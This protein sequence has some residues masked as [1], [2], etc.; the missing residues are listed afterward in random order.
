MPGAGHGGTYGEKQAGKFGKAAVAF[1]EY[2]FKGDPKAKTAIFDGGLKALG[3]EIQHK[4][5]KL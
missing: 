2:G 1:F 4:N 5:W 3:W